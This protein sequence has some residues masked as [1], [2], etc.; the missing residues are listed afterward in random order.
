MKTVPPSS[1]PVNLRD[2]L[3]QHL[4][5]YALAASAAGVS[6]LALAEVPD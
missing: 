5:L 2:S 1:K 4:H 6:M 3:H